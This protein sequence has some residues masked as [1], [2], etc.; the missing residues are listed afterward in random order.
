M[1]QSGIPQLV[2]EL[3]NYDIISVLLSVCYIPHCSH[4]LLIAV[5][6]F[7]PEGDPITAPY[8]SFVPIK[9]LLFKALPI[10]T[11]SSATFPIPFIVAYFQPKDLPR[12]YNF[13]YEWRSAFKQKHYYSV[14]L[15]AFTDSAVSF[16]Q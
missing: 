9:Q 16:I 14:V 5:P 8:I 12:S 2:L 13:G 11:V 3:C 6:V 15:V 1:E 4:Y 10:K 7:K